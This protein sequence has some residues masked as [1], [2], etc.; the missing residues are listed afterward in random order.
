MAMGYIYYM[1]A[2]SYRMICTTLTV[3]RW[4]GRYIS[5]IT[6]SDTPLV[7]HWLVMLTSGKD[8]TTLAG[9]E[10]YYSSGKD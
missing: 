6:C 9:M 2:M 10:W 4:L 3:F 7:A 8:G 1:S 5:F